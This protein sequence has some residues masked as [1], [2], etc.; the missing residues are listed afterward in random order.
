MV[1]DGAQAHKKTKNRQ[2]GANYKKNC[3]NL[4]LEGIF[5]IDIFAGVCYIL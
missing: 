2:Y 4:R 1:A 3:K 5:L